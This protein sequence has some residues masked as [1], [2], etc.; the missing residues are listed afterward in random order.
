MIETILTLEKQGVTFA[1]RPY[2]FDYELTRPLT[3]DQA[4]AI[5][6]LKETDKEVCRYLTERAEQHIRTCRGILEDR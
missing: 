4:E 3:I 6:K 2:G 1:P 5:I